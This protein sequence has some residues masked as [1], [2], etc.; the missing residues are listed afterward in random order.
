MNNKVLA[1]AMAAAALAVCICIPIADTQH[2][3]SDIPV[4]AEV[5][6]AV[7]TAAV[8]P[9]EVTMTEITAEEAAEETSAESAAESEPEASAEEEKG[10]VTAFPNVEF[11]QQTAFPERDYPAHGQVTAFPVTE[12]TEPEPEFPLQYMI[13]DI[14]PILQ[15]PELPSGC[16]ATAL[17]IMLN[18]CGYNISKTAIAGNY[19]PFKVITERNGVLIGEST[20][21]TFAGDPFSDGGLGCFIPAIKGAAEKFLHQVSS[22]MKAY[23]LT[24]IPLCDL[25]PLIAEDVPVLVIITQ[26]LSEPEY[27]IS[28]F[29]DEGE[30]IEWYRGHHAVVLYG[31]DLESGT[32]Y[33]LDPLTEDGYNEYNISDLEHIYNIKGKRAMAITF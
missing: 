30:E 27:N 22:P 33:S 4:I 17:T 21:T 5:T 25:L 23:D 1:A 12:Q 3:D 10:A 31:Y 16:E 11:T 18:Y 20:E 24:G 29:T 15:L 7:T 28:W 26:D 9:P 6:T 14:S 19:I 2:K 32:V 13:E 8:S